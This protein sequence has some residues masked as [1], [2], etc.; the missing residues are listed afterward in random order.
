MTQSNRTPGQEN[1]TIPETVIAVYPLVLEPDGSPN[2][3]PTVTA[4]RAARPCLSGR[5]RTWFTDGFHQARGN[6]TRVHRAT[7]VFA[8]EGTPIVASGAGRVITARTWNGDPTAK[9]GHSVTIDH[10]GGWTTY[11]AHLR[12]APAV[13]QGQRIEAG[14]FLGRVGRT[15][16]AITSCPH[17]HY[18]VERYG[19]KVNPYPALVRVCPYPVTGI[20]ELSAAALSRRTTAPTAPAA[21]PSAPSGGAGAGGPLSGSHSAGSCYCPCSCLPHGGRDKP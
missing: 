18:A 8:L 20:R 14:A 11:Y 4:P 12:D 19:G 5:N 10:G 1:D 21:P 17:L 3:D 7:D 13:T 6:G 16:N 9:G 15:G 2:I